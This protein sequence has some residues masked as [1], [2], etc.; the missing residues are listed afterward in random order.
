MAKTEHYYTHFEPGLYY[1]V[2]NRSVDRKPMFTQERNYEFFLQK[3][4]IY[5]LPVLDVYAWCLMNN[6]FHLMVR[7][8]DA[9]DLTTLKTSENGNR[10]DL[11]TFEKLSN[12]NHD[13]HPIISGAFRRLFQSYAMAFNKQDNRIGTLFQTPFKRNLVSND[14]Y[15]TQMIY[16]I[17]SNPQHHGFID[18]FRDYPFSSYNTI[19]NTNESLSLHDLTTS[20]KL[21]NHTGKKVLDWFGG[22]DDYIKYHSSLQNNI[23]SALIIEDD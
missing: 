4:C 7:I 13:A 9:Q 6:H 18:D 11:T 2:Y 20:E 22:K 1:H 5:L 19:L 8:N 12:L 15:F 23:E 10:Q 14:N 21:S 16:Y 3:L 17:H